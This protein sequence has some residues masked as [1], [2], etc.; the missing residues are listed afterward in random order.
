MRVLLFAES[1]LPHMNGVTH[2]LLQVLRHL[3]RRG[4]EALVV[5]PRSGPIDRDLYGADAALVRSVPLPSYPDVR[6]SVASS[7]YL[8][9]LVDDFR[10]DVVHLASPFVLGWQGLRAADARGVPTVAIYQTD[11][12]GYAERYGVPS[13][14]P[15]LA[16]HVS[17]IHRRA[18]LTLAPSTAAMSQLAEAGVDRLRLWRRG[19][20]SVRFQPSRRSAELRAELAPNGEVLV[21]YVGRLAPEKQVEH[22]RVL[23]SVPGIR[24]VIIGDGPSRAGLERLLPDA[25]FLGFQ[26]GDALAEAV[27][28][29]DV[30]VH[31]GENESFCQT[32][33]EALASGVPVVSTGR[34]GPLDLVESSRTGWLYRPGDLDDLRERVADLA[35][36]AAKRAAF[37]VAARESVAGRSWESL[38]DELVGHYAEAVELRRSG[39]AHVLTGLP[40]RSVPAASETA[41]DAH[42]DARPRWRRVVAVGDSLTEGLSDDSRQAP[43]QFRGWADR[44]AL[45]LAHSK[46]ESLLYAN[47]GVRSRRIADVVGEQLPRAL[48][49]NADLVAVLV[50]GNDLVKAGARPERLTD[51]LAEALLGVRERGVDVLL[52]T[53]FV[54]PRPFLGT[55]HERAGRF[56]RRLQSRLAGSGVMTL[57]FWHHP[58]FLDARMWSEDRVH[59]SPHGHRTLSYRAAILLGVPHADELANLDLG[60]HEEEAE[61]AAP[62]LSTSAW[63]RIHALPWL[64]RRMRGRTAGHGRV[65]KHDSLVP[66]GPGERRSRQ[67]VLD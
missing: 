25:A 32:I 2:S 40:D 21:G 51:T 66:V 24:L 54:P 6:V 3:E 29:L 60:L 31:P 38:G 34:G 47:L 64:G 23:G 52:V 1:F 22:V 45:L 36:D 15:F 39:A 5:A 65:A 26:S 49:L 50:G 35:G 43:G 33:Q 48:E 10:P 20:D 16:K 18:T 57:D 30:F 53:P 12:P 41:L 46:R 17:R 27:A 11:V 67:G 55:L 19:V 42:R 14:A 58:E 28:S 62:T 13:A 7:R 59:L 56:N 4:D 9:S 61:A 37:A 44:L 8:G 63:V